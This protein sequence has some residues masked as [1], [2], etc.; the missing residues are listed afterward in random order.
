MP[1]KIISNEIIPSNDTASNVEVNNNADL[2][3]I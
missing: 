2:F 3:Q 1:H